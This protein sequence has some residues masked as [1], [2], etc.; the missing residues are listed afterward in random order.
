MAGRSRTPPSEVSKTKSEHAGQVLKRYLRLLNWTDLS[1]TGVRAWNAKV[2]GQVTPNCWFNTK[3]TSERNF[4]VVLSAA[5][6]PA[7]R[8]KRTV[9]NIW[10]P[11]GG[12]V[13]LEGTAEL[14]W[15]SEGR[16]EQKPKCRKCHRGNRQF[17]TFNPNKFELRCD[18]PGGKNI[19]DCVEME[20]K[21]HDTP[22]EAC[23]ERKKERASETS[24]SLLLSDHLSS[25]LAKTGAVC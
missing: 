25:A 13:T 24:L 10:T 20:R 22:I 7:A 16:Q 2:P 23:R 11:D 14:R 21:L 9:P 3:R 6:V 19:H 15:N 1:T 4:T 5:T 17:C 8:L 18:D 12:T